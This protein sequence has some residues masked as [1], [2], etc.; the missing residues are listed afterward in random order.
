MEFL[1]AYS[2]LLKRQLLKTRNSFAD[3]G[4]TL[5]ALGNPHH[6]LKF[7]HIAGTNGKGSVAVMCANALSLS[8]EK[9]GLYTSPHLVSICER[10]K[11]NGT[12][13]S[14]RAFADAV[15]AVLAAE[16]VTLTYFEVLTCAAFLHFARNN[17][18]FAVLETGIGGRLDVTNIIARPEVSI[19][20]SVGFDHVDLLGDSIEKIA[21]E[22]AGI[23]KS[24]GICV[25]AQVPPEALVVIK[26][27]AAEKDARLIYAPDDSP[28]DF[29]DF[30]WHRNST[31]FRDGSGG[32]HA[33]S[34]LGEPYVLN[35]QTVVSALSALGLDRNRV[36]DS[37]ADFVWPARF[38]V[39]RVDNGTGH[40]VSIVIDGAQNLETGGPDEIGQGIKNPVPVQPQGRQGGHDG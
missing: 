20:T 1:P 39:L 29:H 23:I 28:F 25:C 8:G 37:L 14:E 7:V 18:S 10:I 33:V 38:Q 3:V 34:A 5:S 32:I 13:I 9:T 35:A 19:I 6:K 2:E 36:L 26:R 17:C 30:D 16:T 24:G 27:T 31:L 12:D 11:I 4:R 15:G 22:K 21:Y 40:C